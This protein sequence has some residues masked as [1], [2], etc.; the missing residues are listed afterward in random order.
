MG[1]ISSANDV[2]QMEVPDLGGGEEKIGLV[3][4]G[5]PVWNMKVGISRWIGDWV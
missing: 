3:G 2:S 1:R 5:A 4:E